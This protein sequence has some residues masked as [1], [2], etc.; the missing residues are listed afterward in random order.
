MFGDGAG[1]GK[2]WG[3]STEVRKE[4]T[5]D[6][7][8]SF[9]LASCDWRCDAHKTTPAQNPGV[10]PLAHHTRFFVMDTISEQSSS[11]TNGYVP[12][13]VESAPSAGTATTRV[14]CWGILYG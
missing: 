7:E 1:D 13:K 8:D 9:P 5:S 12:E 6:L 3:N 14:T 2:E 11:H 10:G 4:D